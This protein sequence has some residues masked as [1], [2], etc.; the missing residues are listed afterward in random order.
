MTLLDKVISYINKFQDMETKI[1]INTGALY[2]F[3]YDLQKYI[4]DWCNCENEIQC[5]QLID[6]LLRVKRV[7]FLGSSS[8]LYLKLIIYPQNSRKYAK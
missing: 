5:K 4:I 8:R 1:K 6:I 2:N 3:N 7:S